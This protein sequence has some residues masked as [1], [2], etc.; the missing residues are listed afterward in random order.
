M[1]T[2]KRPS[3]KTR[4]QAKPVRK[5]PAK[6][7][8]VSHRLADGSTLG[9]PLVRPA[10]DSRRGG[11][12]L[13]G[14]I[15]LAAALLWRRPQVVPM[16]PT[17]AVPEARSVAPASPTADDLQR[18]LDKLPRPETEPHSSRPHRERA[19]AEAE[20]KAPAPKPSAATSAPKRAAAPASG[21]LIFD[22]SA[23]PLALRCW[24]VDGEVPS[25]DVFGAHNRRI[26]RLLGTAVSGA[27]SLQ[28]DGKDE[29][30]KDAPDGLYY[31]RPSMKGPQELREVRIQR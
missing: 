28:W 18:E 7:K 2:K 20:A 29:A 13:L 8:T 6:T 17:D 26:R 9:A 14:V 22:P 19:G 4:A 30:G 12:I 24:A 27:E 23:G 11:W 21:G 25:L 15:A 31:L 5:R 16:T 10:T 3:K 1:A